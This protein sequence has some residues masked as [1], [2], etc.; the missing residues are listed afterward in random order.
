MSTIKFNSTPGVTSNAIGGEVVDA[1]AVARTLAGQGVPLFTAERDARARSGFRLPAG[2]EQVQASASIEVLDEYVALAEAKVAAGA[3]DLPA[4]CAVM[5]GP[6]NVIDCDPRNGGDVGALE[7]R[8]ILPVVHARAVTPSGGVHLLIKALGIGLARG[9]VEGFLPGLDLIGAREDGTGCGFVFISPT[10]KIPKASGAD[11]RPGEVR[12]PRR[13]SP[14]P[15]EPY[16]I[17]TPV[18]ELGDVWEKDDSG[19]PLAEFIIAGRVARKGKGGKS[20]GTSGKNEDS[21]WTNPDIDEVRQQGFGPPGEQ[22]NTARDVVFQMAMK[23]FSYIEALQAWQDAVERTVVED[24]RW[25]WDD[26]EFGRR[27]ERSCAIVAERRSEDLPPGLDEERARV[28][29]E[30]WM[31][32]RSKDVNGHGVV[33]GGDGDSSGDGLG[34]AGGARVSDADGA[35]GDARVRELNDTANAL[36]FYELLCDQVIFV[37][38]IGWHLWTDGLWVPDRKA[39]VLD[40]TQAVCASRREDVMRAVMD[41]ADGSEMKELNKFYHYTSGY[42]GRKRIEALASTD[43]RLAVDSADLNPDPWAMRVQNGTLDLRTGELRPSHQRDRHTLTAGVAF[44]AD[45]RCPGFDA[46]LKTVLPNAAIANYLLRVCGYMLTGAV[47]EQ[48]FFFLFGVPKAGKSTICEVLQRVLGDYAHVA[49]DNLLYE[50]MEHPT[51]LASL[52]GKRLVVHDELSRTRRLNTSRLNQ[53]TGSG[54]LRGRLMR[55]D[56]FN[57]P[58]QFKLMITANHRPS[59][60]GSAVDGVWRRLKLIRFETPIQ[61]DKRVRDYAA[62]LVEEEGPGILNRFLTGLADWRQVQGLGEPGDVAAEAEA[63]RDDEGVFEQFEKECLRRVRADAWVANA[64]MYGYYEA[65]CK[66][67]GHKPD[68]GTTLSKTLR[69]AGYTRAAPC[70]AQWHMHDGTVEKAVHRGWM[71]VQVVVERHGGMGLYGAVPVWVPV[72]KPKA[73]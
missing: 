42:N 71:G 32:E 43:V 26:A 36:R 34:G 35:V 66:A 69:D 68:A 20:G 8:G 31:R 57:V 62:V 49:D 23:N 10:M 2:W 17:F 18:P 51:N 29:V 12:E 4:L 54:T 9:A 22:N 41:G 61:E 3:L 30:Q 19:E 27:W 1:L 5:L 70:Y 48:A 11:G 56:Y 14:A 67:N 46:L 44:D 37:P 53:F 38:G 39:R 60:G 47:S 24:A 65:W 28:V 15:P 59:M 13:K 63:Y 73:L 6:W 50:S 7:V 25:P 33:A 16:G 45:A 55:Q 21:T 52:L 58:I 72:G 64:T 40:M